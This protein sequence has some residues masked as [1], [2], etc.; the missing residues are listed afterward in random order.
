MLA[1]VSH[2][3]RASPGVVEVDRVRAEHCGSELAF[4][5]LE[6]FRGVSVQANAAP[7]FLSF[8]LFFLFFFF[9]NKEK[10]T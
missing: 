9:L 1:D 6:V 8:V 4:Q 10:E 5:H 2:L 7:H 3:V